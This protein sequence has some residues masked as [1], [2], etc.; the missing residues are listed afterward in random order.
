MALPTLKKEH[1]EDLVK[2]TLHGEHS[3]LPHQ[4]QRIVN[5][6]YRTHN[7]LAGGMGRATALHSLKRVIGEGKT[8]GLKFRYHPSHNEGLKNMVS[9]KFDEVKENGEVDGEPTPQ[10][11]RKAE[12]IKNLNLRRRAEEIGEEKDTT[13]AKTEALSRKSVAFGQRGRDVQTSALGNAAHAT[14][15]AFQKAEKTA[16]KNEPPETSAPPDMFIGG[17]D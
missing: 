3:Y 5:A 14:A 9:A 2:G 4:A 10:Q 6:L 1:F 16:P 11:Q 17:V 13:A 15:S 8:A 12:V 7:N